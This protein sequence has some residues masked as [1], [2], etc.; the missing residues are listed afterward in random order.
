MLYNPERLKLIANKIEDG[1]TS[2]N[3]DFLDVVSYVEEMP[4]SRQG[5][6]MIKHRFWLHDQEEMYHGGLNFFVPTPSFFNL[7][8][9]LKIH[10]VGIQ[11]T[12]KYLPRAVKFLE[13]ILNYEFKQE[14]IVY[15]GQGE[16]KL[17]TNLDLTNRVDKLPG[18]IYRCQNAA[19]MRALAELV[20]GIRHKKVN[21]V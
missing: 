9:D 21:G 10:T 15:F 8:D 17:N 1:D 13:V 5:G 12:T 11:T 4:A 16:C 20:S 18:L 3:D 2:A 19:A 14:R 7:L 6:A